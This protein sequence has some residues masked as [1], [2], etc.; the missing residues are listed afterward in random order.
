MKTSYHSDAPEEGLRGAWQG[1]FFGYPLI[2]RR[3]L[4][5]KS[6]AGKLENI[7]LDETVL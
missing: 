7:T 4:G 2:G 3:L 5:L 1:R 6:Q